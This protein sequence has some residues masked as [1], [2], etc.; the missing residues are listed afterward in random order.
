MWRS[1]GWDVSLWT[2]NEV[3]ALHGI[4]RES[5]WTLVAGSPIERAFRHAVEHSD[6]GTAADLFRYEV[7]LRYGGAYADV[8]IRALVAPE[9]FDK[10]SAPIFGLDGCKR[11]EIRF[12]VVPVAGHDLIRRLRDEAVKRAE[13]FIDAGG[14]LQP[15]TRMTHIMNRTGPRMAVEV[16]E[17]WAGEHSMSMAA[18]V[19]AD[20][21]DERTLEGTEHF[22]RKEKIAKAIALERAKPQGGRAARKGWC[23][24]TIRA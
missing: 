10:L 16:V 13:A 11:L 22:V 8:D 1:R 14:W 12:I 9:S 19:R 23:S 18:L 5:A 21:V 7:L 4:K 2:C 15:G 20:L 6:H 3:P 17:Q 24:W